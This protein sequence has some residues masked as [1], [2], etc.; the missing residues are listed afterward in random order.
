MPYHMSFLFDWLLH[1]SQKG[2]LECLRLM[3]CYKKNDIEREKALIQNAR[4]TNKQERQS[5]QTK[6]EIK[7]ELYP[8]AKRPSLQVLCNKCIPNKRT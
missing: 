3:Q 5:L 6:K 2:W 4:Q 1:V 8:L 7:H